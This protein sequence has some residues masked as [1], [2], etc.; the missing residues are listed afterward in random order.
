[1]YDG[2]PEECEICFRDPASCFQPRSSLGPWTKTSSDNKPRSFR[3]QW[4][5]SMLLECS[6]VNC[7]ATMLVHGNDVTPVKQKSVLLSRSRQ[8]LTN[9]KIFLGYVSELVPQLFDCD[10]LEFTSPGVRSASFM[11]SRCNRFLLLGLLL[12]QS[13]FSTGVCSSDFCAVVS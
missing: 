7:H 8:S 5:R 3:C 10:F 13:M 2:H 11:C 9:H 1:M 12:F 4:L 6:D